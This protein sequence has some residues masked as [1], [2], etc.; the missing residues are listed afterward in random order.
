MPIQDDPD[1]KEY[2]EYLEYQDYQKY[3]KND[4]GSNQKFAGSTETDNSN[5][6]LPN[7]PPEKE[8][9]GAITT[10]NQAAQFDRAVQNE[11]T[12]SNPV[13]KMYYKM[14]QIS[15][16]PTNPYRQQVM[17]DA[18]M[19]GAG[20]LNTP[21]GEGAST[22]FKGAHNLAG[23]PFSA[24]E[25]F[26]KPAAQRSSVLDMV[27]KPEQL[28]PYVSNRVN[29]AESQ[30]VNQNITPK[31][32]AQRA[33]AEGKTIALKPGSFMGHDPGVDAMLQQRLNEARAT[34]MYGSPD[35]VEMPLK[36]ILEIRSK[37]NKVSQFRPGRVYSD[38]AIAK[39]KAAREAGDLLRSH[40]SNHPEVGDDIAKLSDSLQKD[41]NLKNEVLVPAKRN[42]VQAIT[43][44]GMD[45]T[46]KL[47]QFD[48]AAGT[49]L[50]QLGTDIDTAVGRLGDS[51]AADI[52]GKTDIPSAA[53]R[54]TVGRTGRMY[55]AAAQKVGVPLSAGLAEYLGQPSTTQMPKNL[56]SLYYLLKGNQGEKK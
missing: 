40:I 15:S 20:A 6:S 3:I 29:Q 30:F 31:M 14:Q 44:S 52:I 23:K 7:L 17:D 43:S 37:L 27:K 53:V 4:N 24:L 33:L 41:Y 16:D 47:A 13:S 9:L 22:L 49:N 42:P 26:L 2:K 10:T 5:N 38:E 45:K 8:I 1:Y 55:D 19:A 39:N 35:T 56:P 28:G 46:S 11:K 54:H 21:I 12:A 36:D 25:N 50:R 48:Q 32:E 51:R 34:S 18:S